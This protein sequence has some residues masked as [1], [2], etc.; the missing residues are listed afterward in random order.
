MPVSVLLA[1]IGG[2]DAI[3]LALLVMVLGSLIALF[4]I[5]SGITLLQVAANPLSAA[6]GIPLRSHFRLTIS[7]AFNLLGTVLGPLVASQLLLRGGLF[8]A[9]AAITMTP[10]ARATSLR[11]IDHQF[12][13]IAVVVAAL[14]IV[15][16]SVPHRLHAPR[17]PRP[18]AG[19][20]LSAFRSG[21][22]LF[23]VSAIFLYVG[24][25]V[26]AVFGRGETRSARLRVAVA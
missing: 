5:G 9:N 4:V 1:W 24:I 21:W 13:L 17:V 3:V 25:A 7:Q 16:W 18:V 2:P 26:F 15:I 19:G 6:L 8:S 20:L 10:Q 11:D 22:G 23:G 12:A 14:G